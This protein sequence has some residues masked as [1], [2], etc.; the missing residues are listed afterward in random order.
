MALRNAKGFLKD[1]KNRTKQ[2]KDDRD[3][4]EI[5]FKKAT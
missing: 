5:K 1:L 3:S 2:I 4:L